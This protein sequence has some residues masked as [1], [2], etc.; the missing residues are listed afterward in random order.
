M[1]RAVVFYGHHVT[2]DGAVK[3]EPD[4]SSRRSATRWLGF[5]AGLV[6]VTVL[7]VVAVLRFGQAGGDDAPS[8]QPAG[9]SSPESNGPAE[10]SSA[11]PSPDTET[12]SGV[13][14]STP[15]PVPTPAPAPSGSAAEPTTPPSTGPHPTAPPVPLESPATPAPEVVA[16]LRSVEAVTASAELPGEIGGPALEITLEVTNGADRILDLTTAVVNLYH[17]TERV[18]A[19][20]IES[21]SEPL[22]PKADPKSVVTGAHVFRVPIDQ[23]QRIRVEVDLGIGRTVV[24]FEGAAPR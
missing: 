5:V 15:T 22:P 7:A 13:S 20:P 18:P 1:E 3:T 11:E 14:S 12:P 19:I 4:G 8:A 2:D 9:A 17:G 23:R 21:A 10:S 24:L 16:E 6:L